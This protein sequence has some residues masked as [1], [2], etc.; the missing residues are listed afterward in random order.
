MNQV[1]LEEFAEIDEQG[2]AVFQILENAAGELVLA[3]LRQKPDAYHPLEAARRIALSM[4]AH[5]R[6]SLVVENIDGDYVVLVA[7]SPD[8]ERHA[9]LG[10]DDT[11]LLLD[12]DAALGRFGSRTDDVLPLTA[13]SSEDVGQAF[14]PG[15]PDFAEVPVLV[16]TDGGLEFERGEL[17]ESMVPAVAEHVRSIASGPGDRYGIIANPFGEFAAVLVG[18][19]LEP[20]QDV[21]F[22]TVIRGRSLL[23][24]AATLGQAAAKLRA[25]A[26]RLD[27]AESEGWILTAPVTG[28]YG[29]PERP[30]R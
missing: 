10:Y 9:P 8:P 5:D 11:E 29:L 30:R 3:G 22:Q 18:D 2:R 19:V 16:V 26:E 23:D 13:W 6:P 15:A 20:F 21:R 24:G 12:A 27:T 28:D 1:T 17:D 14:D 4:S 25:Y 7:G